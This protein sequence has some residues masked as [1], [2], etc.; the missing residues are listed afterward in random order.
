MGR[1]KY[2]L[3]FFIILFF[4]VILW[5]F[6]L[7]YYASVL[8]EAG[9]QEYAQISENLHKGYGFKTNVILPFR[10]NYQSY[11]F[12]FKYGI[13]HPFIVSLFFKI[14]G[15][16][17]FSV[18]FSS[19]IFYFA[20]IIV[21]FLLAKE[22]FS[23][24]VAIISILFFAF[25]PVVLTWVMWGTPDPLFTFLLLLSLLTLVRNK[26]PVLAGFIFGLCQISRLHSYF[27][28]FGILLFII[29]LYPKEKRLQNIF[30]FVTGAFPVIFILMIYQYLNA[31]ILFSS[32]AGN[33]LALFTLTY[34]GPHSLR[35]LDVI[36]FFEFI[37]KY[38][39]DIFA[40]IKSSLYNFFSFFPLIISPYLMSF[41][42]CG[43]FFGYNDPKSNKYKF[44]LIFLIFSTILFYLVSITYLERYILT[45]LPFII[46]IISHF[47]TILSSGVLKKKLFFLV[48]FSFLIV[49][50]LFV[51]VYSLALCKK[52]IEETKILHNAVAKI[53]KENFKE[54]TFVLS[55]SPW[56][57]SWYGKKK[58]IWLP[59]SPDDIKKIEKKVKI[60]GIILT[61]LYIP[62][63]E[64]DTP[65]LWLTKFVEPKGKS[66]W[67]EIFEGRKK[68][69]GF[70]ERKIM[71][72]KDFFIVYFIK[73]GK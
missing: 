13:L 49:P 25:N 51:D 19:A 55:D 69:D 48:L 39:L 72:L 71:K 22:M 56:T 40:K 3:V 6:Y 34:P 14:F 8:V 64:L 41:F 58:S 38:P 67:T 26:S 35:T 21:L 50:S 1:P 32:S 47:I 37:V 24:K 27:Y 7:H 70:G 53:C 65:S 30:K 63:T 62:Q 59:L 43:L 46:I 44:L 54:D 12:P 28:L 20:I 17:D 45:L 61:P 42:F 36:F 33:Y 31:G 23:E 15:V 60:Q 4:S 11:D 9:G 2:S 29:F 52:G 16:N 18:V 5:V 10:L 57:V 73:E 68:L 66:S